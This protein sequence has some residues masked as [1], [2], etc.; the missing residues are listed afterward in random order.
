[1]HF[2][3]T[4]SRAKAR[5]QAAHIRR[6]LLLERGLRKRLQALLD[7]QYAVIAE[8]ARHGVFD[9]E[10]VVNAQRGAMIKALSEHYTRVGA[11]FFASVEA[12]FADQSP[13]GSRDTADGKAYFSA[14]EQ[15]GMAAE[16]WQAF[17]NWTL[18]QAADKVKKIGD[19]TKRSIRVLISEGSNN[20]DSY[21]V[22]AESI[23]SSTAKDIN[24]KRAQRIAR[25]ETH[26]ASTYAV[27]EAVRSTRVKFER[28]W[29]SMADERTRPYPGS[30]GA[31]AKW[32]HR[33]AN[34]QRR[35]M[36]VAFDVS[37]EKL[38]VPGDPKASAGNSINCRCVLL[39]HAVREG[40]QVQWL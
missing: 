25:T 13:K 2:N 1:V 30:T 11:Q 3:I 16:F 35:P 22:I 20:G 32:D 5:V 36:D 21:K 37:G 29:V 24:L 34:G 9:V 19:A 15:K 38:M 7:Y 12:S 14:A 40:G 39:Y 8:H 27:N 6:Q 33:K 31:A 10:I 28:E 23:W 17:H 18:S 26:T 4:N